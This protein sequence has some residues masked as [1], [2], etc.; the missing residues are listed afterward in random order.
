M[1]A[2]AICAMHSLPRKKMPLEEGRFHLVRS[3]VALADN[4]SAS[5]AQFCTE[6]TVFSFFSR[7]QEHKDGLFWRREVPSLPV[8]YR[9]AR[10][11]GGVG[12]K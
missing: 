11:V 10:L 12:L 9:S 5:A 7:C 4:R 2:F 3:H 8:E 1:T 6:G